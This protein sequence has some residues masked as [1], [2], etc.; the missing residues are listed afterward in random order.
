M[1]W[2]R[3]TPFWSGTTANVNTFFDDFLAYAAASFSVAPRIGRKRKKNW[4]L[5]SKV[6]FKPQIMRSARAAA[7]TNLWMN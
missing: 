1:F 3:D 6:I 2:V 7:R 5:N 4:P